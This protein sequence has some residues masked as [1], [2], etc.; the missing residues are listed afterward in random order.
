MPLGSV[1]SRRMRRRDS[2]IL[3]FA[4]MLAGLIT[5]AS[6][7]AAS[8]SARPADSHLRD[9]PPAFAGG[10]LA[11]REIGKAGKGR[12]DPHHFV[13]LHPLPLHPRYIEEDRLQRRMH[14]SLA[15]AHVA[16]RRHAR[17]GRER[18]EATSPRH[19]KAGQWTA[20]DLQGS[21]AVPLRSRHG[22]RANGRARGRRYLVRGESRRLT[23]SRGANSREC[24]AFCVD[25]LR[26]PC[27]VGRPCRTH[28]RAR[29][30]GQVASLR[31]PLF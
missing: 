24:P 28:V 8:A 19:E 29:S 3:A 7:T 6:T 1:V 23:S 25:H 20:S 5:F 10:L 21:A 30:S 22:S 13:R 17:L 11:R 31:E 12:V 16:E 9:N 14:G 2:R 4:V 27:L 26:R 15:T 18:G